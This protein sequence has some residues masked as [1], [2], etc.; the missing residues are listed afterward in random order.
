MSN[1]ELSLLIRKTL[2]EN[3][4]TTK[5]A[6]V[7]VRASLYDTSVN[8]TVKNPLVR[9]SNVESIVKKFEEIDFDKHSQEILAGCN[10]YVHCQYEY[11]IFD[12][13]I[14]ELEPV[15]E[16]VLANEKK[17]SGHAIASNKDKEVHIIKMDNVKWALTE[18]NKKEHNV[19]GFNYYIF[20]AQ[21]LAVA[22]YRFKNIG[23]IYA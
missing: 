7:K 15:A 19:S 21:D 10:V 8:I 1:K 14:K 4:Y 22:M 6:S 3:G 20:T 18:I 17:Y 23:T 12:V 5:D 2:K 9:L 13:L 16:K 11:G